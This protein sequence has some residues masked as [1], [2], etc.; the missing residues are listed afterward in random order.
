R[1]PRR[2]RRTGREPKRRRSLPDRGSGVIGFDLTTQLARL[3]ERFE[4]GPRPLGQP[5]LH[6]LLTP[7]L[8]QEVFFILSAQ[9]PDFIAPINSFLAYFD[10]KQIGAFLGGLAAFLG[11]LAALW[12]AKSAAG[13]LRAWEQQ[14]R[15]TEDHKL[16]KKV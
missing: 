3:L 4:L 11:G 16:A 1:R 15:G 10:F 5:A 9:M 6:R 2:H 7:C 12:A 14:L 13:G 8:W